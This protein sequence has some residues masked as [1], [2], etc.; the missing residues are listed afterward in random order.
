LVAGIKESFAVSVN[1]L[2]KSDIIVSSRYLVGD[3]LSSVFAEEESYDDSD[4]K[5]GDDVYGY[6]SSS[7]HFLKLNSKRRHVI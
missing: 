2:Y 7:T 3:V 5:S 4:N 1:I 6:L